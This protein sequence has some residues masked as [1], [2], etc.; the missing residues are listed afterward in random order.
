MIKI[1]QSKLIVPISQGEEFY[2]GL[3]FL[4]RDGKMIRCPREPHIF[5][6]STRCSASLPGL[7]CIW[8]SVDERRMSTR[9]LF[10]SDTDAG[11]HLRLRSSWSM[12]SRSLLRLGARRV[13]RQD[14]RNSL[15]GIHERR[16]L[17]GFAAPRGRDLFVR[18]PRLT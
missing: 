4:S 2:N 13:L 1:E 3:G 18:F 5:T 11:R 6:G 8:A 17:L 9:S 12:L 7:I 16:V 10:S 14:C 15:G